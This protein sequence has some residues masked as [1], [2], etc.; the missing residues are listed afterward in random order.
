MKTAGTR[1][2]PGVSVETRWA[3]AAAAV[4]AAWVAITLAGPD[5]PLLRST[6]SR[7]TAAAAATAALCGAGWRP[8]TVP[9]M[10]AA[11]AGLLLAPVSVADAAGGSALF[12]AVVVAGAA[13]AELLLV[14]RAGRTSAGTTPLYPAALVAAGGLLFAA[15][16][17]QRGNATTW[18]LPHDDAT[19][20][21]LALLAAA[22]L[23]LVAT[24]GPRRAVP[25]AVPGLLVGLVAVPGLSALPMAAAGALLAT[26]SAFRWPQRPAPALAALAMAAAAVPMGLQPSALLAAA[27]ALAV[28]VVHPSAM[29]LG[30]PGTALLADALVRGGHRSSLVVLVAGVL[31]T[32]AVVASQSAGSRGRPSAES[33]AGAVTWALF[34]AGALAA[35]L[36]LSPGT[37]G[38]TGAEGPGAYDRG[39]SVA[40]AAAVLT[41][42]GRRALAM[43]RLS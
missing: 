2:R 36:L 28:L 1:R 35:W 31:A 15:L 40:V 34:P 38:W 22:I 29:L 13:G 42:V 9:S 21:P 17:L 7:G 18:A 14:V 11:V 39:A 5:L 26:A 23:V 12:L 30:L 3:L 20:V 27:A 24:L 4:A 6:T 8:R 37:W 41:T 16:L 19:A 10:L 33:D 32:F 43:R 25:A